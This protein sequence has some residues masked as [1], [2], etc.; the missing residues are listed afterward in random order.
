MLIGEKIQKLRKANFLTQ[1]DLGKRIGTDGNTVS[2][3]ERNKL[4][5]GS[6]YIA[7]LAKVLN[8]TTDYF[9]GEIKPDAQKENSPGNLPINNAPENEKLGLSYWGGVADNA[10]KVAARGDPKELSL[11]AALLQ[12]AMDTIKGGEINSP[13]V[14]QAVMVNGTNN[15]LTDFM[16]KKIST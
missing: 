2:R 5:V 1:D 15:K 6:S 14:T 11:V 16:N 8:T 12:S 10:Q 13:S 4:G 9:M 3:W 7:K